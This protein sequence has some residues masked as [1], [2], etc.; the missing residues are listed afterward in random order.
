MGKFAGKVLYPFVLFKAEKVDVT[1]AIF[2][3]EMHHV[4]DMRRMGVLKWY[5]TYLWLAIR[6]GYRNHPYEKEAYE[7]QNEPLTEEEKALR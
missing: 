4:H 1:D 5:V 2:K 7:H 6:R 3:H